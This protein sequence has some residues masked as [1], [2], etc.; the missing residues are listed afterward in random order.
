MQKL[1]LKNIITKIKNEETFEA[2]FDEA[3]ARKNATLAKLKAM[4]SQE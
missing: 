4:F 1:S 2:R 3:K